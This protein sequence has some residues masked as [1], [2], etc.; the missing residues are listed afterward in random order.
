MANLIIPDGGTIGS[1]S[2]TDAI[3]ISSTG[4][5]TTADS[6]LNVKTTSH[7]FT[8]KG[9]GE[10]IGDSQIGTAPNTTDS[11][12]GQI[13]V[14]NGSTKLFGIT[15]HGY[16]L[17]PNLPA[18][19]VSCTQT[20]GENSDWDYIFYNN[21]SHYSTTTGRFTAPVDGYYFFSLYCM[22]N[23]NGDMDIGLKLN[24]TGINNLQ[25]F[26]TATGG[27]YNGVSASTLM[28]LNAGDYIEVSNNGVNIY[29]HEAGRHSTFAGFLIG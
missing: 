15:E 2:D 14:Y 23:S 18:F 24:G 12:S 29:P 10:S 13:A 16:V 21:G 25:P 3:T 6:E 9:I 20:N 17:K 11:D 26:Q 5:V 22:S 27:T 4:K 7:T 1:T 28:D 19:A 8:V